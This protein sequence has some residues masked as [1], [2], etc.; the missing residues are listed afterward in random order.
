MAK[1]KTEVVGDKTRRRRKKTPAEEA[2]VW[3]APGDLTPW[4]ANPRSITDAEVEAVAGSIRRFGFG[5]PVV[6]TPGGTIIAG[7][8]RTLAA[9]RLGLEKIPVRI[10][11]L[12]AEE[13]AALALADN[14]LGELVAW[15]DVALARVVEG[16]Q[17][18]EVDLDGLGWS[19]DELA[20]LVES[21]GTHTVAE[22]E[23]ANPT[24][25]PPPTT[26]V[27]HVHSTPGGVYRLGPHVLVC[28]D[29]TD[30]G[31]WDALE[32]DPD[33]SACITSPPYG[34]GASARL[35]DDQSSSRPKSTPPRD[36][37]YQ[38]H[39]DDPKDWPDLMHRWTTQAVDRCTVVMANVQLLARNRRALVRWL[40]AWVDNLVDVLVWDKGN[41]APQ[42]QPGIVSNYHENVVIL[43]NGDPSRSIPL[44]TFQGNRAS[45]IRVARVAKHPDNHR[46]VYPV[47]LPAELLGLVGDAHQVVDP[48]AGTGTT[49]IAA[50]Q[51][52]LV[53]KCIELDPVYCDVIRRRWHAWALAAGVD[54]GPDSIEPATHVSEGLNP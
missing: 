40:H 19:S 37:L 23:R 35:R 7:H 20:D 50:A 6:A 16:L 27:E 47:E 36:S 51:A 53:A 54:P 24:P 21:I 17:G 22:H 31:A 48:F 1:A 3:M 12:S 38:T 10:L 5:A 34:I 28:G 46:A 8:T 32:I 18:M 9:R 15:D 13:A 25:T 26:D 11:D 43:A 52:G 44:A 30:P 42:I 14:K 4:G 49:L 29:A 39:Q 2:A 41:G 33:V 45:V